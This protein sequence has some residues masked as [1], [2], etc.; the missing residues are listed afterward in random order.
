MPYGIKRSK[1]STY[2]EEIIANAY[3]ELVEEALKNKK[4]IP[5]KRIKCCKCGR[6]A[7]TLRKI[8]KDVYACT[9]C[10]D[11]AVAWEITKE[12][13]KSEVKNDR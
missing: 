11:K 10:L 1:Y 9:D 5:E 7:V 3:L 2:A 8:H 4:K 6:C 12:F 13:E